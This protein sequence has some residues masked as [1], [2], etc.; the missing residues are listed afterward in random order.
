VSNVLY[1]IVQIE[2]N[3]LHGYSVMRDFP[4]IWLRNGCSG[5]C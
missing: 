3:H 5:K 4:E 1:V 2:K